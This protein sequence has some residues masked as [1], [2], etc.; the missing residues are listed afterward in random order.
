MFI[1]IYTFILH[2]DDEPSATETQQS[3]CSANDTQG[4]SQPGAS[5]SEAGPSTP[6]AGPSTS[7]AGPSTSV[8]GPSTSE[9]GPS[10]SQLGV[11]PTATITPTASG[12][13]DE[14]CPTCGQAKYTNP[15][16]E[17]GLIA[18]EF[19]YILRPPA[20]LD[21]KNKKQKR[22]TVNTYARLLTSKYLFHLKNKGL[23]WQ[24]MNTLGPEI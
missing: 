22:V 10:T 14:P 1:Q 11:T 13:A 16:V 6:E 2:S 12:T 5:T 20:G 17:A 3:T 24:K 9:A 8:A 23:G 15:L 4:T 7:E 19:Q 21:P 18:E